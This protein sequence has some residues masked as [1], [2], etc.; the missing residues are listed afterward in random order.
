M[1]RKRDQTT[2][3]LD[4]L[5]RAVAPK[6]RIGNVRTVAPDVPQELVRVL[7]FRN[8][9]FS[10]GSHA[11]VGGGLQDVDVR[12]VRVIVPDASHD[13]GKRRNRVRHPH[14]CHRRSKSVSHPIQPL[15]KHKT[16]QKQSQIHSTNAPWNVDHGLNRMPT[17]SAPTALTT[18]SVTSSTNLARF[19]TEPPYASVLVLVF[20][21]RN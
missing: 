21:C 8:I 11:V 6:A 18:A 10:G 17:L 19:C 12:E 9:G 2:L 20:V 13:L 7:Q 5:C 4:R 1:L 15:T 14:I 3:L 16:K